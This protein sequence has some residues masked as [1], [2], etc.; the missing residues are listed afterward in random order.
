MRKLHSII[1]G[2]AIVVSVSVSH[3]YGEHMDA[4]TEAHDAQQ[5][6]KM[7]HVE[8]VHFDG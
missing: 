7:V 4:I 2:Y 6:S 1:L 5:Y 8:I 3:G